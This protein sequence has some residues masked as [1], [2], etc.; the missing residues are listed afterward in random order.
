MRSF[1]IIGSPPSP[2][3]YQAED[4][5]I[6]P[7]WLDT[8]ELRATLVKYYAEITNFDELVGRMREMLEAKDV[9]ENTLFIVCSEQG[10]QLPFAK[11]TCYDN[12]LR[13]GLVAHWAGVIKPGSVA[14]EL[15]STADVTPTFVE[16]AGGKLGPKAVDGKSFLGMLKGETQTLHDYVYGAFTNCRI[17]DNRDRVYPIRVIR[18]KE[19]SLIW[20]PN[21]ESITSNVSLSGVLHRLG[22]RA[23]GETFDVPVEWLPTLDG[24]PVVA[25][26]GRR[27]EPGK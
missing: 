4:F 15:V 17:I 5:T 2:S 18:N 14:E 16:A 21:H 6:P 8:P 12:G 20:N 25:A 13:T 24:H 22:L 1:L 10:T 3:A 9:W 7:Y 11:W 23:T 26:P 19:F 27:V